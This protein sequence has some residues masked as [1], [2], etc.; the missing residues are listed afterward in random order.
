MSLGKPIQ[1]TFKKRWL[2]H[3]FP[4]VGKTTLIGNGVGDK[5]LIIRPPTESVESITVEPFPREV[6]VHDWTDMQNVVDEL[7]S[8]DDGDLDWVWLDAIS[9]FQDTGLDD[10]WRAEK[11]RNPARAQLTQGMSQGEYGRNMQRLSETI[12]A[13]CGAAGFNFG[14]TAHSQLLANPNF[15]GDENDDET[16]PETLMPWVQGKGMAQKVCGYMG[17]VFYLY[18]RK[19]AKGGWDRVLTTRESHQFFAME[20]SERLPGGRLINPTFADIV[21]AYDR[22][23]DRP[24]RTNTKRR[25][26]AAQ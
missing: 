10:I 11:A 3:G 13:L 26:R 22:P 20:K 25:R 21:S 6:V 16:P 9:S 4:G 14:V 23:A 12:R 1:R 7:L 2:I 24:R 8:L 18:R 19:N 15:T 5:T 17:T